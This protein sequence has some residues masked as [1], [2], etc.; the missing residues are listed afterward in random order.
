MSKKTIFTLIGLGLMI[1]VLVGWGCQ[2]KPTPTDLEKREAEPVE[3]EAVAPEEMAPERK[4]EYLV[5]VKGGIQFSPGGDILKEEPQSLYLVSKDGKE[6]KMLIEFKPREETQYCQIIGGKIYYQLFKY[7]ITEKE[8]VQAEIITPIAMVN[9][10]GETQ[11]LD[12]VTLS[13]EEDH[14]PIHFKVSPDGK[15]IVWTYEF[16]SKDKSREGQFRNQLWVAGI[17][18]KNKK[19]VLE[20]SYYLSFFPFKWSKDPSF[21]YL[22]VT[23]RGAANLSKVSLDTGEI[24]DILTKN[25]SRGDFSPD[26]NL[27][28]YLE[29]KGQVVGEK[30]EYGNSSEIPLVIKDITT[31]EEVFVTR[32]PQERDSEGQGIVQNVKFSPD[33]KFLIYDILYGEIGEFWKT[34]YL[35]DIEKKKEELITD[36]PDWAERE[37]YSDLVGEGYRFIDKIELSG[38][39]IDETSDWKTYESEGWKY[40]IKYPSNLYIKSNPQGDKYPDDPSTPHDGGQTLIISDLEKMGIQDIMPEEKI[41]VDV[42]T[43][44]KKSNQTLYSYLKEL[45]KHEGNESK[46]SET[47]INGIEGFEIKTSEFLSIS[48]FVNQGDWVYQ[49]RGC[50]AVDQD[51]TSE[52]YQLMRKIFSTFKFTK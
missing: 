36:I 23:G 28:A 17:N 27:V 43:M 39:E 19:M 3:E 49:L 45:I 42:L 18:G 30:E 7:Q 12:F 24:E 38:G 46:I 11:N 50:N 51:L 40:S 37:D 29:L 25:E 10:E 35:I 26:G 5:F 21:I 31:G 33:G 15:R 41:H 1:L 48:I 32:T 13:E 20:R 52:N 4:R 16:F 8:G 47:S 6:K 9:S 22:T 14:R 2:P 34:S 44:R